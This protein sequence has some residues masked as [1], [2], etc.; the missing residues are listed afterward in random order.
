M[1]LLLS[2]LFLG[3]CTTFIGYEHL[4]QPNINDDGYD[5]LC[6]GI[7]INKGRYRGDVAVCEN[8]NYPGTYAKIEGRI[9]IGEL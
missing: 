5:L 1:R 9:L 6:W 4:S 7:E 3:G 8:L 2:T